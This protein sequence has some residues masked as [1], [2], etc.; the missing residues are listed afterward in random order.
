MRIKWHHLHITDHFLFTF[1]CVIHSVVIS[2]TLRCSPNKLFPLIYIWFMICFYGFISQAL[3]WS[4]YA[5]LYLEFL[6]MTSLWILMKILQKKR[7]PMF[8]FRTYSIIQFEV[9]YFIEN[10]SISPARAWLNCSPCF[11]IFAS[12]FKIHIRYKLCRW[13]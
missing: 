2:M 8:K 6:K 9:I 12:R 13:I 5:I 10:T 3:F 11:S 4:C 7:K 1:E